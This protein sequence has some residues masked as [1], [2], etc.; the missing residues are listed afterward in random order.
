LLGGA[1]IKLG[2]TTI[3]N[4]P[5]D[6]LKERWRALDANESIDTVWVPDH[7]F[8]GWLD[9]WEALRGLANVTHRVRF[10]PLVSPATTHDPAELARAAHALDDGRL[11]LGV[12]T[13]GDWRR[14]EAWTDE[15]VPQLGT[16]PLTVGGAGE[17]ALRVA[18]RHA[19]RW[20]YSPGRADSRE[21]ARRMGQELNARLDE[22][23]DRP[24][25]R[26]ALIAYPFT[27]EDDAP[28]ADVVAAWADAGFE[29]LIL[30]DRR[31]PGQ[32]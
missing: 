20:N 8:K 22:L 5:I 32:G 31:A 25:L 9:A 2:A 21:G 19:S 24:I 18:A 26:S 7:T 13:G 4:A 17:T 14:F 3:P 1:L 15:L 29:E 12:G 23:A 11:E 28:L 10:G 6:E 30:D 16:V 27:A